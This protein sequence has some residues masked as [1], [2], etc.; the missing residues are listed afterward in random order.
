MTKYE[1]P[2]CNWKGDYLQVASVESYMLLN[3]EPEAVEDEEE[4]IEI[5][6]ECLKNSGYKHYEVLNEIC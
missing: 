1:C 6:P 3:V 5:C 4:C 2:K